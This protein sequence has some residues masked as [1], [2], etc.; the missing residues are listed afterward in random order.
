[1][2]NQFSNN[3]IKLKNMLAANQKKIKERLAANQEKINKLL[4]DN[5]AQVAKA[6]QEAKAASNHLFMNGW[7]PPRMPPKSNNRN[8]HYYG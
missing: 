4:A 8:A 2:P 3:E 1:M 6:A 7:K 5:A